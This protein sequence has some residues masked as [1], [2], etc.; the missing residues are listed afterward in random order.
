[1][2][3]VSASGMTTGILPGA[4]GNAELMAFFNGVKAS[5]S[6]SGTINTTFSTPDL[7]FDYLAAG[8]HLNIT[9]TVQLDDHVGGITTQN[10]VVTVIGTNDKP[11]LPERAGVGAPYRGP[12]RVAGGK[13]H[14]A[15]RSGFQ[16]RRSV[17]HPHGATTVTAV[18]SGGGTI[19][20]SN[21]ALLAALTTSVNDSSRHVLGD[22]DWGILRCRTVRRAF[23]P[24]ARR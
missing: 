1:V 21:A 17:R 4:L 24:L 20:L 8:E 11:V 12:E 19:P 5:G 10:A 6:S 18:R 7:A 15:R 23:L 2:I 16:R 13:S 22:V 3:A 14:R 9:Y